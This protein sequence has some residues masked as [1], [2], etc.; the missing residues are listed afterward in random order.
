MD[1][2]QVS[3]V[4]VLSVL[5]CACQG[6]A[7]LEESSEPTVAGARPERPSG[8][9]LP[10][11][12][13]ARCALG[14]E[15][16]VGDGV[17]PTCSVGC[18]KVASDAPACLEVW[19]ALLL[20]QWDEITPSCE[21]SSFGTGGACLAEFDAFDNCYSEAT[22]TPGDPDPGIEDGGAEPDP[23]QEQV[24]LASELCDQQCEWRVANDCTTV[25]GSE[26]LQGFGF[27]AGGG[28]EQ[29]WLD[30]ISCEN[31]FRTMCGTSFE[32]APPPSECEASWRLLDACW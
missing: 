6:G 32:P 8:E 23:F 18:E 19:R 30:Y 25:C 14:E 17:A 11:L 13:A 5:C 27:A 7:A 10:E 3:R 22:R 2:K 1:R 12:C 20:C 9:D 15:S 26:C 28:C 21:P 29:Q 24:E 4:A 31:E 16:C